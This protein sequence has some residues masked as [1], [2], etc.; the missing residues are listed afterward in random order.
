MPEP[1]TTSRADTDRRRAP[2]HEF[3]RSLQY[4]H[5]SDI[6]GPYRNGMRTIEK[7]ARAADLRAMLAAYRCLTIEE[8]ERDNWGDMQ[9]EIEAELWRLEQELVAPRTRRWLAA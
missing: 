1:R 2:A 3:T 8:A 7:A 9:V 5:Q 6:P 4:R